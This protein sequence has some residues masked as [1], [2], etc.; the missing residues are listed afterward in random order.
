MGIFV[1]TVKFAKKKFQEKLTEGWEYKQ[2]KD[3]Y[4]KLREIK[5]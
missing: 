3:G 1:N 5:L 4:I 2:L